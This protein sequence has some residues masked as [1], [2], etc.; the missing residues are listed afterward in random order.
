M[1]VAGLEAK[2]NT[3]CTAE[4]VQLCYRTCGPE[5]VGF[6]P[7][8]CT[9]GVYAEPSN[10]CEYPAS[11]DYSCYKIPAT[12]P[13]ATTC[14]ITSAPQSGAACTAPSCTLCSLGGAYLDSSGASKVGHC[15]CHE[16]TDGGKVWSCAGTNIWPCPGKNGC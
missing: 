7:E 10:F 2:K 5:S 6:K 16:K 8:T 15:V 13:D 14:G 4:D 11:G 3:A 12:L 1:T 9:A